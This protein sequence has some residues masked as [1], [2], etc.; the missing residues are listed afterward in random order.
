MLTSLWRLWCLW[1]CSLHHRLLGKPQIF[2]KSGDL[3]SCFNSLLIHF[4]KLNCLYHGNCQTPKSKLPPIV[5][6]IHTIY[7]AVVHSNAAQTKFQ[8]QVDACWKKSNYSVARLL[9]SSPLRD[10]FFSDIMIFVVSSQLMSSYHFPYLTE[11]VTTLSSRERC[12]T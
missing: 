6:K 11:Y 12:V 10:R 9:P 8:Q 5:F 3:R 2:T 1:F 4:P 7:T